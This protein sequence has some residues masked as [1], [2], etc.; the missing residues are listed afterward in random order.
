MM[1]SQKIGGYQIFLHLVL[2][3]LAS[4]VVLLG[5]QNRALR[6]SRNPTPPAGPVAGDLLR[7]IDAKDLEGRAVQ[8]PFGGSN[9][10][11]MLF[12]WTTTCPACK[13]NLPNWLAVKERFG[14]R[15]NIVALSLDSIDATKPYV[16]AHPL[17]FEVLVAA[18]PA[19]FR[20]QY[21][22]PGV[23]ETIHADRDGRVRG[24]WLGVLP[25]DFL[26]RFPDQPEPRISEVLKPDGSGSL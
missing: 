1:S 23:P 12:V 6:A 26:D 5:T 10:E 2:I 22:I 15:Y 3:G 17:P 4:L 8:I 25:K 13:A 14:E 16:E 21:N 18:D 19:G 7:P 20:S 24:A 11:T 9:R